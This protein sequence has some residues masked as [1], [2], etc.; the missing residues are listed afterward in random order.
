[1]VSTLLG[2]EIAILMENYVIM[3]FLPYVSVSIRA[4]IQIDGQGQV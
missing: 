4:R 1:M 2:E 3:T